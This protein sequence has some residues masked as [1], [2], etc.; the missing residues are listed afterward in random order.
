VTAQ[1]PSV[2]EELE[3]QERLK[4]GNSD[5]HLGRFIL[6]QNHALINL[7]GIHNRHREVLDRLENGPV[8]LSRLL[9]NAV[10]PS[11]YLRCI[12]D[13][14]ERGLVVF[15]SFT[16]TDAA[17]VLNICEGDSNAALLGASFFAKRIGLDPNSF[18][19]RV[20]QEVSRQLAKEILNSAFYN[21]GLSK[22]N[23]K[24]ND[25][26]LINSA[27]QEEKTGSFSVSITMNHPIVAI[28]APVETYIPQAASLLS[29]EFLI[30]KHAEVA[31]AIG[32]VTGG[33]MQ[34]AK[35]LVKSMEEGT[36]FRVFYAEGIKDFDKYELAIDFGKRAAEKE[37]EELAVR[38]GAQEVEINISVEEIYLKT[39]PDYA[40]EDLFY[41]T[42]ITGTAFGRPHLGEWQSAIN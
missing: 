38:A 27:L 31:N 25:T 16:P 36:L 17:C 5:P 24:T 6:K 13:L 42:E 34:K 40:D 12:D 37:C 32:A 4:P 26:Y 18:C 21:E 23:Q 41:E 11:L 22:K 28:G 20:R 9:S 3:K 8:A 1:Y 39:N 33:I 30:P 14:I 15:S 10:Y 35:I 7:S 19:H 29:G 2:L